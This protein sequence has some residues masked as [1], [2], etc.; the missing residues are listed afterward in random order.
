MKEI[1][2]KKIQAFP[3]ATKRYNVLREWLQ[4]LILKILDDTGHFGRLAFVGGTALRVLFDLRRFSEDIDFSLQKPCDPRFHLR[5]MLGDLVKQIGIYGFS[6]D[7]RE[8]KV[9]AVCGVWLRFRDV[10]QEFG[11]SER[12]GQ[13]LHIK[14]EVDTNPP[15]GAGYES[16]IVQKDFLFTVVHHDLPTLFAGKL[17]AFLFRNYTKGRDL[18]DLIWYLSRKTPVNKKFF[19]NGLKQTMGKSLSWTREEL[20]QQMSDKLNFLNMPVVINDVQPFLDD[21][22]EVHFFEKPLLLKLLQEIN[23]L[24]NS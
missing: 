19:E 10:L 23:Y 7:T 4:H 16:R 1:L 21:P 17:Q 9:G 13:K 5:E 18:Y 15:S 3:D 11:I 22:S 14:L 6:L 2:Q 24:S 12:K 20:L 8:K